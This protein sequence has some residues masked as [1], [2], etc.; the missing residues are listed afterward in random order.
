MVSLQGF[1]N[2]TIRVSLEGFYESTLNVTF[3]G[4]RLWGSG[5]SGHRFQAGFRVESVGLSSGCRVSC[6]RA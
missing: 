1:Y 2:G 6:K 3:R 4:V 5:L